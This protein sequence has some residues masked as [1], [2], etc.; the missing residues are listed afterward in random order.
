MSN[1]KAPQTE[2]LDSNEMRIQYLK[3]KIC[4]AKLKDLN[5][6][7]TIATLNDAVREYK[8]QNEDDLIYKELTEPPTEKNYIESLNKTSDGYFTGYTIRPEDDKDNYVEKIDNVEKIDGIEWD[9]PGHKI[10]LK[11]G[12]LTY[13]AAPTKHGKTTALFNFLI[14]IRN[15]YKEQIHYFFSFE[16]AIYALTSKLLSCYINQNLS[17]DNYSSIKSYM[18]SGKSNMT[19]FNQA[20]RQD[21]TK[22]NTKIALFWKDMGNVRISYEDM[23]IDELIQL[24]T[25]IGDKKNTGVIFIDYMQLIKIGEGNL[26]SAERIKIACNKL[27]NVAVEKKLSIVIASQMTRG[28][29]NPESLLAQGLSEGSDIEKSANQIIGIWHCGKKPVYTGN[30]IVSK[31]EWESLYED[32]IERN[33]WAIMRILANR[34]GESE[35]QN[36]FQVDYNIKKIYPSSIKLKDYNPKKITPKKDISYLQEDI[37]KRI[38]AIDSKILR[39]NEIEKEIKKYESKN[40]SFLDTSYEPEQSFHE[41]PDDLNLAD[42]M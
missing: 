41:H 5:A 35:I 40:K 3:D 19:H 17:K 7:D 23:D 2:K 4:D 25:I 10:V 6:S 24:I 13:V 18:K 12:S 39:D 32:D 34:D 30:A 33:N 42:L 38:N 1:I 27:K 22:I 31:Q 29:K 36:A 15:I 16:E 37:Q 8:K 9:I 26:S 21:Q 11:A 20:A 14:N 28:V